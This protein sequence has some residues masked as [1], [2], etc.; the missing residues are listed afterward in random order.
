[1][2]INK[3]SFKD[4]PLFLTNHLAGDVIFEGLLQDLSYRAPTIAERDRIITDSINY[5]M[6][7]EVVKSGS[8]RIN[9]WVEGWGQN[10][11]CFKES[12]DISDL[13]PKYFGKYPVQRIR[14][15]FVIPIDKSFEIR[16]VRALQY[17]IFSKYFSGLSNIAEFGSGTG[18]NLIYLKSLSNELSLL[19]LEWSSSGVECLNCYAEFFNEPRIKAVN[20]DFFTPNRTIDI[21]GYGV[22]TFAA[23]EQIGEGYKDLV[24]YWIK[25]KPKI[26]VNVEPIGEL[27]AKEELPCYLS[28][29]YFEKRNYLSGYYRHLLSLQDNGL[30]EIIDAG[31]TG[32]GSKFIE[33]YSVVAWLPK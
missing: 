4:F 16:V 25:G 28:L 33:G 14:G 5:L 29:K 17:L 6:Q 30:I 9:D 23:L 22:Y 7:E 10:L 20:F 19:G 21:N 1:M 26:I 24:D 27:L 15:E 32:L 13:L 2:S 31:R 3:V 8:H 11:K 12:K 18:H